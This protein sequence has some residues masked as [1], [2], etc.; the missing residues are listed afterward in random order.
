M[1]TTTQNPLDALLYNRN[2]DLTARWNFPAAIGSPLDQPA[3]IG[4]PVKLTYSFLQAAPAYYTSADFR[5]F[6]D[7]DRRATR[8]ALSSIAS[9]VGLRFQEV[10]GI[11]QLTFGFSSQAAGQEGFAFQPGYA[12]SFVNDRYTTITESERAGDVWLNHVINR[13]EASWNPGGDSY[14]TLLHETAHAL[15]LK[16]PFEAPADG[17]LLD[18]ELDSERH[19]VM[20]Y[21]QPANTNLVT[22]QGDASNFSIQWLPASPS[23]LMPLDIEALQYLYGANTRTRR[24]DDTYRWNRNPEIL[25]TIYD[26]GGQ[27]TL[28]CS[29]QV[30]DCH[31]DLR[32]GA[33]SSIALRLTD[34]QKRIGLDLPSWFVAPLPEGTYDGR[35]NLAIARGVT[36]E[37]AIGGSGA[38]LLIGNAVSNTLQGGL[39]LDQLTGAGGSDRF[40]FDTAPSPANRDRITDF[41]PGSDKLV[42]D[43]SIFQALTGSEAGQPLAARHLRI[44]AAPR[45]RDDYLV[46]NPAT[47]LLSY[48]PRG[49]ASRRLL[50][51]AEIPLAGS[52]VPAASDLLVLA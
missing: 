24:G 31:L 12:Y 42:L 20:S 29:N 34:A 39:G 22:V 46:Y 7:R 9:M 16:H 18:L 52:L 19:T 26:T 6:T 41:A 17:F 40:L 51:I 21:N 5:P 35:D 32:P 45:D 38:D 11:G 33:Y 13:S 48:A 43:A 25:E 36:I 15:G 47:D 37:N 50:P 27:D 8:R 4:Q 2:G 1:T 14:A 28:D 49:R 3:G 10:S 30:F 23:T 44:G